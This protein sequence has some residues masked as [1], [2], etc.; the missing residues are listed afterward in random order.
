VSVRLGGPDGARPAGAQQSAVSRFCRHALVLAVAFIMVMIG[1]VGVLGAVAPDSP[2]VG[3][4]DVHPRVFDH[5]PVDRLLDEVD[6][7]HVRFNPTVPP[8]G[9]AVSGCHWV[10]RLG[11]VRIDAV[12]LRGSACVYDLV[13][14]VPLV[15]SPQLDLHFDLYLNSESAFPALVLN[16]VDFPPPPKAAVGVSRRIHSVVC[17]VGA[18][19]DFERR[20]PF[21]YILF[22]V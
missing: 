15:I 17:D 4:A 14:E 10:N 7:G 22:K 6:S 21:V 19:T 16:P 8:D 3:C 12:A 20:C 13:H 2:Q 1:A 18:S 11:A 9:G 5:L